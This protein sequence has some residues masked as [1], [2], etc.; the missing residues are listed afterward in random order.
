[1]RCQYKIGTSNS[2]KPLLASTTPRNRSANSTL[3]SSSIP[4]HHGY[5]NGGGHSNMTVPSHSL[6]PSWWSG[7]ASQRPPLTSSISGSSEEFA[8][9]AVASPMERPM[10]QPLPQAPV[11]VNTSGPSHSGLPLYSPGGHRQMNGYQVEEMPGL[12]HPLLNCLHTG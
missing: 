6:P 3:S 11:F 5:A 8:N 2:D 1:M 4:P 9:L 10:P 12:F 7:N